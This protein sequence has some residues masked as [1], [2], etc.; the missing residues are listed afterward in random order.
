LLN[1]KEILHYQKNGILDFLFFF[2]FF[3]VYPN[4]V[5]L[6]HIKDVPIYKDVPHLKKKKKKKVINYKH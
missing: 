5:G 1:E 2:F 4:V 6:I 3:V